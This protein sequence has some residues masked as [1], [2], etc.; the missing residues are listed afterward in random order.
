[1]KTRSVAVKEFKD[2]ARSWT[3][4]EARTK[5][6]EM[7]EQ[8]FRLR[9]QLA[10]GQ[11][12]TLKKIRELKRDLAR[13]KTIERERQGEPQDAPQAAPGKKR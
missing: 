6:R 5:E 3:L 8:L 7:S 9:F 1:M 11:T 12:D 10:G 13:L 4:D 2:E